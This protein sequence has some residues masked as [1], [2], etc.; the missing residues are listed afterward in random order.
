MRRFSAVVAPRSSARKS[1]HT[2]AWS[3]LAYLSSR[4]AEIANTVQIA[5]T[6]ARMTRA[7]VEA[8][9]KLKPIEK[10]KV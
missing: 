1:L 5:V 3:W 6:E 2:V 10:K 7:A 4:N 9:A 8:G